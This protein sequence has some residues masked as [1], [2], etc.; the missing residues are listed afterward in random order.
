MWEQKKKMWEHASVK[1]NWNQGLVSNRAQRTL[2]PFEGRLIV[3]MCQ[4][5]KHVHV[6]FSKTLIVGEFM[7]MWGP[8]KS[9]G[10]QK[11]F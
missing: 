10:F 1:R 4:V 7:N 2:N 6:W 11:F 5:I 3:I 8:K 9:P